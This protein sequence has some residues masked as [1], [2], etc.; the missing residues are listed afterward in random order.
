MQSKWYIRFL[1]NLLFLSAFDHTKYQVTE[2]LTVKIKPLLTTHQTAAHESLCVLF[3]ISLTPK[4]K[5]MKSKA[6]QSRRDISGSYD[7]SGGCPVGGEG[8]C[9]FC[10]KY[11][12]YCSPR[13]QSTSLNCLREQ[14]GSGYSKLPKLSSLITDIWQHGR[15]ICV[16]V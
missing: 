6:I 10:L 14:R 12:P 1:F 13:T 4:P 8:A 11:F 9:A 2:S 16:G 5:R 7:L 15:R 3:F